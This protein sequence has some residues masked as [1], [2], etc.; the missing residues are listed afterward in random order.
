M[1][2]FP[3]IAHGGTVPIEA[4][5]T[6]AKTGPSAKPESPRRSPPALRWSWKLTRVAG[7]DIYVHATFLLLIAYVAFSGLM[8]GQG[9]AV[10]LTLAGFQQD[11][12]VMDGTRLV[13]VLTHGDVLRGLAERGPNI[14]VDHAMR[15]EFE[16]AGPSEALDGA[17]AR[18]HQGEHGVLMVV[19]HERVVGI[20]TAGNVGELLAMEGAAG[21]GRA[22]TA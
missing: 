17:L 22:R 2:R 8:A 16:I 10:A 14:Q 13:G 1:T 20:L 9:A 21:P 11:F 12:P 18:M 3:S 5:H 4:A 6:T 19:E 7:I 15:G